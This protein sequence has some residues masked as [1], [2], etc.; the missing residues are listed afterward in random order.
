PFD[1]GAWLSVTNPIGYDSPALVAPGTINVALGRPV[2]AAGETWP[3]LPKENLTD[4]SLTTV[5]HNN[6]QVDDFYFMVDLG[7]LFKLENIELF[8]RA[9]CCPE[10][11]SNFTVTILDDAGELPG[12]P[13]WSANVR[14]N[15]TNSGM[16]G[17]DVIIPSRDP[18]GTFAGRW[19]KVQ[20]RAEGG[21]RYFQLAELRANAANWASRAPVYASGATYTGS[22][23][24]NLTDGS[25]ASFSHNLD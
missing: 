2:Y 6:A 11:L 25:L 18:N 19:I 13:V 14:T 22:P 17:R 7:A 23:K 20:A 3:G 16:G 12:P 1:D 9:D 21:V 4:G 5:T 24:E 10:R 8:N 15:N